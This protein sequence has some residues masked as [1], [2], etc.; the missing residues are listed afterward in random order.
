MRKWLTGQPWRHMG[1]KA[2]PASSSV[3][4]SRFPHERVPPNPNGSPPKAISASSTAWQESP[5]LKRTMQAY[6]AAAETADTLFADADLDWRDSE[7]VRFAL[8][9]IIEGLAPTN[10]PLI[11]PLGWK[12]LVLCLRAMK[13]RCLPKVAAITALRHRLRIIGV[14]RNM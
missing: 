9:N 5:L 8:D 12:A 6:L 13:M 7:K 11:S 14:S 3:A 4:K 2:L 1:R 10:N